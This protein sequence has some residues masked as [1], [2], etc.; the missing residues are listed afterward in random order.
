MPFAEV[1][2][3]R[4]Y[5]EDAGETDAPAIVFSHG[6][7][8]DHSMFDAQ[9]DVLRD[10]WR[11]ITWDERA[12]G[13]TE[14]TTEPFT[15]WDSAN[16]LLGLM[17]H[18]GIEQAVLAGMSQGGY[19]SLRAALTA[20]ERVR[21]LVLIDTQSGTEDPAHLEG[22]DQIL[23]AWTNS[24]DGAPQEVLDIV[25]AIILGQGWEGTAHWQEKWRRES[26]DRIRQAYDTLVGREDD[27]T[28]RL[29]ELTMPAVVIHGVD[30]VAIDAPTAQQLADALSS[31][32]HLIEGAGHA[33]NLTHPADVNEKLHRFLAG[34]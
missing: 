16:D 33:A 32:L 2:G 9:V 30:D 31:E 23:D 8:M 7:Y 1:N 25:A 11:C 29:S 5:Y 24:P 18:L 12:H 19:L 20:P 22:Y 15:Y 3:Q 4:L 6:L 14:S 10:R 28:S 34:L 13:A 27:V 26:N 21:A 17:D